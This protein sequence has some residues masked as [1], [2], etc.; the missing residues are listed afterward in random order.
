MWVLPPYGLWCCACLGCQTKFECGWLKVIEVIGVTDETGDAV[1]TDS[2]VQR[3]TPDHG[4]YAS[5][6]A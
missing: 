1:L 3:R 6:G 5:G 2:F 4:S